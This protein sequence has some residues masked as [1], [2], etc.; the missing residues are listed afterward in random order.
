MISQSLQELIS[1]P[2]PSTPSFAHF[3][4]RFHLPLPLHIDILCPDFTY[5]LTLTP[6]SISIYSLF[7]I[8]FLSLKHDFQTRTILNSRAHISF[9]FDHVK[10][11]RDEPNSHFQKNSKRGWLYKAYKDFIIHCYVISNSSIKILI[12]LQL[13]SINFLCNMFIFIPCLS[14]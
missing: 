2:N 1:K 3:Y 8:S 12:F 11:D 13:F 9:G 5:P 10:L 4:S 7:E 6:M 14:I